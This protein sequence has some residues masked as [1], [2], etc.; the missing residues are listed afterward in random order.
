MPNR[1]AEQLNIGE[2]DRSIR[3]IGK[4]KINRGTNGQYWFTVH[5]TNGLKVCHSEQYRNYGDCYS[6]A[7]MIQNGGGTIE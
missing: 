2:K 3:V 1:A 7:R 4:I 5:A 6:A